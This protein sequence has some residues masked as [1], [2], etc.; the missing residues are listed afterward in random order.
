[1]GIE[2]NP[3]WFKRTNK[4]LVDGAKLSAARV[5]AEMSLDQVAKELGCNKSQVSRWE[6][7]SLVPS[8]ERIQKL[9]KLFKTKG[10]VVENANRVEG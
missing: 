4:Y 2:N 9:V 6:R 5:A 1:M 7:N 3:T 8:D 10:F